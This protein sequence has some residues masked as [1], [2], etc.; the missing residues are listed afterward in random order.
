MENQSVENHYALAEVAGCA[1]TGR[2]LNLPQIQRSLVWKAAQIELLWDSIL[3]G[4]PIGSFVVAEFS[5]NDDKAP[6][7]LL[8]GQQRMNAIKLGYNQFG[9]EETE[10]GRAP[11]LWLD[12]APREAG[13]STRKYWA[14]L[15]TPAHPWGYKANDKC[16][17]LNT[18]E[19]RNACEKYKATDP[20]KAQVFEAWPHDAECPVPFACLIYA[21]EV[22]EN[23]AG[24]VDA[25]IAQIKDG[26]CFT[27]PENW[28][29][30]VGEVAVRESLKGKAADLYGAFN[31]L[32]CYRVSTVALPSGFLKEKTQADQLG[33]MECFFERMNTGGT[34]I[35]AED[36]FYSTVKANF[37][38]FKLK[39]HCDM[40]AET[41]MPP[42]HLA[43]LSFR[44]AL[45][46]LPGN[47]KL[48]KLHGTPG[49]PAI[50]KIARDVDGDDYKAI[51]H[52]WS[53]SGSQIGKCLN[54]VRGWISYDKC[55]D[56]L[57]P[58]LRL[59]LILHSPDVFLL[60]L[61]LA[62]KDGQLDGKVA[63]QLATLLHWFAV[64]TQKACNAIIEECEREGVS[65]EA[66]QRGIAWSVNKNYILAPYSP[67]VLKEEERWEWCE[68]WSWWTAWGEKTPCMD[69]INRI[70]DHGLRSGTTANELILYAQREYLDK[71]FKGYN[72]ADPVL[73]GESNRPWD[74]DHIIPK[75]WIVGAK[76]R[77]RTPWIGLCE[78]WAH[79]AGNLAAIPF[80]I[81]RS[82]SNSQ[83]WNEYENQDHKEGLLYEAHKIQNNIRESG[84]MATE[85]ASWSKNRMIKV[86]ERWFDGLDLKSLLEFQS[87]SLPESI[88]LRKELFEQIKE[89]LGTDAD[90]FFAQKDDQYPVSLNTAHECTNWL[91]VGVPLE[92]CMPCIT[93]GELRSDGLIKLKFGV[94]MAPG[95]KQIDAEYKKGVFEKLAKDDDLLELHV[96]G[97]WYLYYGEHV[98]FDQR[99]ILSYVSKIKKCIE[100][101]K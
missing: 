45:T 49:L 62:E 8:D 1:D 15:C 11:V 96:N 63:R 38:E 31:R 18:V 54:T 48:Q 95:E 79:S 23:A 81:N 90:I 41:V 55:S 25:V 46:L 98:S 99:N 70:K 37:K 36:L 43:I 84:D 19:K 32:K 24:F 101:L 72:P 14:R 4:F 39:E 56:G 53:D 88:R 64:D 92:K 51:K 20:Y 71:T 74:M 85:F 89:E 17:V 29:Q 100:A 77:K 68:E 3:R 97:W 21:A 73:F 67:D 42:S 44:L 75:S 40:L 61:W 65:I 59:S 9:E 27:V 12:L 82:K 33:S 93:I 50:R 80:G 57:P 52:M 2:H 34:R 91:T 60:L 13:Q 83:E 10:R 78:Q 47:E 5:D 28:H 87:E 26:T 86:Y 76:G 69:W 22:A 94:R 58:V 7:Q 66:I 30:K 35:S 6:L 16:D